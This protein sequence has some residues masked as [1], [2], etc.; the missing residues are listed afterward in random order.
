MP[1]ELS[2]VVATATAAFDAFD[3]AAPRKSQEKF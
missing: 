1:A 2:T 3:H